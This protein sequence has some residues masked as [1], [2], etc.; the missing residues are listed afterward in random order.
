M[1]ARLQ[2]EALNRVMEKIMQAR[3]EFSPA[4]A[5]L[6][7]RRHAHAGKGAC[8]ATAAFGNGALYQPHCNAVRERPRTRAN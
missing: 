1:R 3:A 7:Q 8:A 5:P 2:V 6:A 4:A